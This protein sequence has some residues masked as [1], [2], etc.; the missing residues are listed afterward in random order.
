VGIVDLTDGE[1]TPGSPG[2]EVRL[3]EARQAAEILGARERITLDLPNRR[4]FDTFEARAALATV[5][6]RYRPR[7]V[8]SLGGKTPLASPDHCQS[9]LITEAAVFYMKLTKW[10]HHFD[11]LA[12]CE[13]PAMMYFFLS[14]RSLSP[15]PQNS[16]VIDISD[17]LEKKLSAIGAYRTQF[18]G[19]P[20]VL[21][22]IR[23]F[24]R[25]QGQ[26]AGFSAGE[27]LAS[28]AALGTR[29]LMGMICR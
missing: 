19:R 27:V 21:D 4:L 6:R 24:N 10:E 9:M 26:A 18:A 8:L 3:A 5:L 7:L 22:R 29:D 12:P 25:Q 2:P 16:L 23:V 13:S 17:T 28:P 14:L 1:P 20:Q 15:A 11:N